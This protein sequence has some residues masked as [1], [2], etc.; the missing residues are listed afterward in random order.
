MNGFYTIFQTILILVLISNIVLFFLFGEDVLDVEKQTMYSL[1][2]SVVIVEFIVLSFAINKFFYQPIVEIE[3]II[4]KFYIGEFKNS[5]IHFKKSWNPKLNFVFKFFVRTLSTLKNIKSEFIH[6]KEIKSEVEIAKEIQGKTLMKK[7]AKIP[8]FDTVVKTRAAGEIG[9]DSYDIIQVEDN[10]YVYVGDATGHGVGAGF[11]M[12]MVNALISG[13]AKIFKQGNTILA[14]TNEILKPRVKA[15]LLM[16]L[17]MI[18]WDEKEK[19]LFM[20]GAGHEYLLVYKHKQNKCYQIKS[21][22]VALGMIKD[23]SKLLKEQ[24]IKIEE[25]DILVLYSDGITEAINRPKKDGM[26]EMFGEQRLMNAIE[27]TP[28]SPGKTI[29]SSQGV[30]NNITIEL[31]KFMGYKHVQLDDITLATMHY[32]GSDEKEDMNFSSE[33]SEDHITEWNW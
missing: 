15:N 17:L 29:K 16:S 32:K 21:G 7:L 28:N 30:F 1:L 2:A 19:R 12:I 18:R 22:G 27:N 6:G 24:E 14:K 20:T 10:Y 25:N 23:C 13:F 31:S 11:I 4:K 5:D 33:I 3:T 8:S 9:G 26:E